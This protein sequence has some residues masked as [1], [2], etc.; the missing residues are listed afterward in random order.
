MV[1]GSVAK[2]AFVTVPGKFRPPAGL[3]QLKLF[4][5]LYCPNCGAKLSGTPPKKD[6]PTGL[7]IN[8]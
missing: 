2:D 3:S 8:P 5:E 1:E 6:T 7:K 4:A